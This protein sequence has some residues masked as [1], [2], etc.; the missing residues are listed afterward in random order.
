G[1]RGE[2]DRGTA[3]PSGYA[4]DLRGRRPDRRG[5][6]CGVAECDYD[7]GRHRRRDGSQVPGRR[8][9][10]GAQVP[11]VAGRVAAERSPPRLGGTRLRQYSLASPPS[12]RWVACFRSLEAAKRSEERRVGK[13]GRVWLVSEERG[14]D[15]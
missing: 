12:P 3:G 5:R 11:G 9:G 2:V 4:D 6:L 13:E 7:Q 1:Q 8:P 15:G 14:G 10:G